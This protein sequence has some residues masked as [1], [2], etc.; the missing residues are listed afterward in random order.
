MGDEL[1]YIPEISMLRFINLGNNQTVEP[2]GTCWRRLKKLP[3]H[4]VQERKFGP[5]ATGDVKQTWADVKKG[6]E[7][8]LAIKSDFALE[9][10]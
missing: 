7:V 3:W 9:R 6:R 10:D 5:G 2:A 1:H 4:C 8:C